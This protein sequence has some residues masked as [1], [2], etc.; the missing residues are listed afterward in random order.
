MMQP[1]SNSF[2]LCSAHAMALLKAGYVNITYS[3]YA[4]QSPEGV[5]L[6]R[7]RAAPRLVRAPR[8]PRGHQRW[9][10]VT[11]ST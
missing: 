2:S 10:V 4:H 1:G 11:V 9:P 8:C 6:A 5:G 3:S 7:R